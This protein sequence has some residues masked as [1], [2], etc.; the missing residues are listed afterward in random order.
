MITSVACGYTPVSQ[1]HDRHGRAARELFQL[2][3]HARER[4]LVTTGG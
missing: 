4:W 2:A 3:D 1:S